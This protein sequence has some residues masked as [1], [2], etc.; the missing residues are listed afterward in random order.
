MSQERLRAARKLIAAGR[1][2]AAADIL[3]QMGDDPTAQV[4]LEK[5]ATLSPRRPKRRINWRPLL[6]VAALVMLVAAVVIG[7]LLFTQ[8]VQQTAEQL[9]AEQEQEL[10][11]VGHYRLTNALLYYCEPRINY[12]AETCL[13]WA[14][15][16][17]GD[18]FTGP[19]PYYDVVHDC[20]AAF[21]LLTTPEAYMPF[22]DCLA[23]AGVPLP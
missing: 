17:L 2:D 16:L 22:G 3:R 21:D 11:R 5:L 8:A 14:D 20:L 10:F 7:L 6:L 15:S 4:W 13:D 18:G 23:A 19:G 9:Q 12:G 1:Y